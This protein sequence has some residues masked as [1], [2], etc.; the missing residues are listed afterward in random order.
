MQEAGANFTVEKHPLLIV[1]HVDGVK[2][3]DA[4][5]SECASH[6]ATVRTD[7]MTQLGVVGKDYGVVQTATGMEAL[8]ILAKR[9]DVDIVSVENVNGG[10]RVRVTALIGVTTFLSANGAPNTLGN[11]AVFEASHDGTACFTASVYTLRLEC[12]NGMTS[13]QVVK[14][15]KLRH[16]SKVSDRVEATTLSILSVL[17]GD[18][19][20]ENE[21]FKRLTTR[22][23]TTREF[24][25]FTTELL[26]G[27]IAE[28]ASD[29]K[30]TRRENTVKELTEY[31]L[32]G[33]QGAG[34]TAWGAYN[35]VTR[36]V[37]AKREGIE[38]AKKA[39]A[40]FTSNLEG[41]G[42]KKV[43]RARKLLTRW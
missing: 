7:T 11:F 5:I 33:N 30:K 41:D 1:N 35:S 27:E 12:F 39:A 38:D 21:I 28:D 42:Q 25:E 26:G 22:P 20:A 36:W 6:V 8:D 4:A 24:G 17:I 29:A 16:T 18:V 23:M 32:G 43:A 34:P 9:G 2:N 14:V 19:A 15:H 37:E 40:K 3:P 10:A 13:R 31:F